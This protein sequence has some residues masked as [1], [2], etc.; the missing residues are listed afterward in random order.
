MKQLLILACLLL[1][2]FSA[3]RAQE[4]HTPHYKC[5]DDK[6]EVFHILIGNKFVADDYS[7]EIIIASP[8]QYLEC[9]GTTDPL[10]Y[11]IK[12]KDR[13]HIPTYLNPLE[14][15]IAQAILIA[16]GT[17]LIELKNG[18]DLKETF[19]PIDCNSQK[20]EIVQTYQCKKQLGV[21][22]TASCF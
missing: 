2:T 13:N 10:K 19:I 4:S 14:N 20:C 6:G 7:N 21:D 18:T 17:S 11:Y 9:S 5:L 22:S 1:M 15:F 3:T 16:G 8:Q 12:S